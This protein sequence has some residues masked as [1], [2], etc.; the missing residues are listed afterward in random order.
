MKELRDRPREH[1]L[2]LKL[3]LAAAISVLILGWLSWDAYYEY[4]YAEAQLPAIGRMQIVRA[5]IVHLDEVL[6][7]SAR[8]ATERTVVAQPNH[9]IISAQGTMTT[10]VP[11]RSTHAF[12]R[13]DMR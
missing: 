7:M 2:R 11:V 1:L 9:R 12:A 5:E 6:T 3:A 4:R 10:T 13:K 8:M